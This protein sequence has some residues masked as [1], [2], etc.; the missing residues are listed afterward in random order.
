MQGFGL[1][2]GEFKDGAIMPNSVFGELK[3]S[4]QLADEL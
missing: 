4:E 3:L 1:N 2:L